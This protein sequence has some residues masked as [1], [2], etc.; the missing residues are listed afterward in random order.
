MGDDMFEDFLPFFENYDRLRC[1]E[2]HGCILRMEASM[3]TAL[4][5]CSSLER[6]RLEGIGSTKSQT[7]GLLAALGEQPNLLELRLR[8]EECFDTDVC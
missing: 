1:V 6:V 7:E 4:S 2:V 8:T 3:A 5:K